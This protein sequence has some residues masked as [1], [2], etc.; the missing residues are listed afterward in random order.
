[1][2]NE[3]QV[4]PRDQSL[5]QLAVDLFLENQS[6]EISVK[7]AVKCLHDV[8]DRFFITTRV[9]RVEDMEREVKRAVDRAKTILREDYG[10]HVLT[11]KRPT[12][13]GGL[14]TYKEIYAWKIMQEGDE[15]LFERSTVDKKEIAESF[16]KSCNILVE[17]AKDINLISSGDADRKKLIMPEQLGMFD[18]KLIE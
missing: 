15:D 7:E 2:K 16:M 11:L 10:L 8:G 3:K 14:R 1:M 13:N 17:G 6:K 9:D 4:I 18:N 5:T 12:N